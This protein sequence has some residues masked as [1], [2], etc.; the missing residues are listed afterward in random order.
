MPKPVLFLMLA[1]LVYLVTLDP[2]AAGT[3]AN[4]FFG[5]VG[6]VVA[7]AGDFVSGLSSD[8]TPTNAP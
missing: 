6:D 5:W 1:F 8:D 3:Q 2:G 4:A 7:S